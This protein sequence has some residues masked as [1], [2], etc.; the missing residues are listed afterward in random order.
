ML[1]ITQRI[2]HLRVYYHL[3]VSHMTLTLVCD[4]KSLLDRLTASTKLT[5]VVPR[6]FLFSLAD[7]EMAILDTF[8]ELKAF[9]TL[10]HVEAHQDTKHPNRPPSYSEYAL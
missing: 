1:A 4:R 6:R 10:E 8:R 5:R 3:N 7:A 2:L 9:I